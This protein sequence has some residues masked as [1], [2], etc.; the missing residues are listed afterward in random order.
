MLFSWWVSNTS[1]QMPER[2]STTM[3]TLYEVQS[4]SYNGN[5]VPK[6]PAQFQEQ[7]NLHTHL[8]PIR[9][10]EL[11]QFLVRYQSSHLSHDFFSILVPLYW[12]NPQTY[13]YTCRVK[14][15]T[16]LRNAH[17]G[18]GTS[19]WIKSVC[20]IWFLVGQMPFY[21]SRSNPVIFSR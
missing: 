9:N 10:R 11:F 6:K 8:P 3:L 7:T 15:E 16:T 13:P 5:R 20:G 18:S 21:I 14:K 2:W 12:F 4:S 17:A 19:M 1:A